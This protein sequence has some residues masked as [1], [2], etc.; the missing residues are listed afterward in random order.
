MRVFSFH[1]PFVFV[2]SPEKGKEFI[3]PKRKR[4]TRVKKRKKK[5]KKK[6]EK[7]RMKENKTIERGF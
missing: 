3:P 4:K 1:L 7:E 5:K 6:K 2:L